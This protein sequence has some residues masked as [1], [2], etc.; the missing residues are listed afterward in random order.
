MYRKIDER[1]SMWTGI[2][3]TKVIRR[4]NNMGFAPYVVK[5]KTTKT[6]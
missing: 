5:R 6:Y 4:N 3:R 1:N 2:W